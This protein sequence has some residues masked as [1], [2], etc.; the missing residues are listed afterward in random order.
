MSLR[1]KKLSKEIYNAHVIML[2]VLKNVN[3]FNFEKKGE[4]LLRSSAISTKMK[5][6]ETL[7]TLKFSTLIST[8]CSEKKRLMKFNTKLILIIYFNER[9]LIMITKNIIIYA[10]KRCQ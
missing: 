1:K 9:R 3:S 7:M 5:E 2:I 6:S 4:I 8:V 10:S